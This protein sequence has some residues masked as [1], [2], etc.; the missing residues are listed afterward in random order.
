MPLNNRQYRNIT[1]RIAL[2][3][4][5]VPAYIPS[6]DLGLEETGENYGPYNL[7]Y[8]R[9]T[10]NNQ[11]PIVIPNP[12]TVPIEYTGAN[13]TGN[14]VQYEDFPSEHYVGNPIGGF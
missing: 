8:Y 12:L 11:Q 10:P 9:K 7:N 5:T 2:Q 3:V 6:P 14:P 1:D 13:F 4:L